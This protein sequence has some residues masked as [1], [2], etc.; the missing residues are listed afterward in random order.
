MEINVKFEGMI[1]LI[2]LSIN[3]IFWDNIFW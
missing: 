2:R 3:S 1:Y